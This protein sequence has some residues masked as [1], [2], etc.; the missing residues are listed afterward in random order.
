[1]FF[2]LSALG[3]FGACAN[4]TP[5][6]LLHSVCSAVKTH[7]LSSKHAKQKLGSVAI[8]VTVV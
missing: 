4:G 5:W 1:M 3:E 2:D 6:L 7:S 8:F